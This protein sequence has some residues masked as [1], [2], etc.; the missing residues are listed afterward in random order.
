MVEE[1]V[2]EITTAEAEEEG[3]TRIKVAVAERAVQARK[4]R[5]RRI[6]WI[7]QSTWTRRLVSSS[8]VEEKV[9]L[10]FSSLIFSLSLQPSL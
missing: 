4:G 7:C 3:T 1:V 6:F 2:E 9:R 5:R 10:S 8:M